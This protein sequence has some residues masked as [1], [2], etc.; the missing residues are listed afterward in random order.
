MALGGFLISGM[1][2]LGEFLCLASELH[3]VFGALFQI[4]ESRPGFVAYRVNAEAGE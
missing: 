3:Y 1:E 4:L 2:S